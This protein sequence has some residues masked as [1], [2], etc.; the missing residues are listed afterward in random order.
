MYRRVDGLVMPSR[1]EGMS[2]VILEAMASG[3]PV[4]A[5]RVGGNIDLVQDGQTGYL[6]D[7]DSSRSFQDAFTAIVDNPETARKMGINA[8]QFVL[9]HSSWAQIANLYLEKLS[10]G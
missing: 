6:F 1:Y 9:R 5:S 8:R 10:K 4:L 2:N 3:L 7:L